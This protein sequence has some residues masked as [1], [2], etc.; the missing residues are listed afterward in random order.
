[1]QRPL[2][3]P[4]SRPVNSQSESHV[5]G[6]VCNTE[7]SWLRARSMLKSGKPSAHTAHTLPSLAPKKKIT[8]GGRRCAGSDASTNF[9]IS[10]PVDLSPSDRETVVAGFTNHCTCAH[11]NNGSTVRSRSRAPCGRCIG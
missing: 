9:Q 4:Y 10:L 2:D 8:D 3:G 7:Q 6:T 5:S 1:M 11:P